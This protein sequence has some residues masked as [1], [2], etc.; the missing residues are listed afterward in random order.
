VLHLLK[1]AGLGASLALLAYGAAMAQGSSIM[2]GRVGTQTGGV[3]G[4]MTPSVGAPADPRYDPA[5]EYA[6]AIAA[7]KA[8]QF[9]DAARAA[10]HVTQVAP[11]NP[12][13][14]RLLGTAYAG[15]SNWTNSRRAYA[16]AVKLAPDNAN[17]HAGLGLAMA[18]L[19]DPK[20][21]QQLDWLKAKTQAC[22]ET[23]PDAARLKSFTETVEGA[24]SAPA[25]AAPSNGRG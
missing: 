25:T 13:G 21:Q 22:G 20:A 1:A 3:M 19:K 8:S 17:A 4:S 18:N 5:V 16:K 9:K 10:T 15:D 7:I 24:M 14:W 23:C 6:K 12:D 2:A 11:E